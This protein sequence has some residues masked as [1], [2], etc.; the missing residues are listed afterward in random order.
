[1]NEERRNRSLQQSDTGAQVSPLGGGHV[2]EVSG[3]SLNA[4]A[5]SPTT[6][7][8]WFEGTI[9]VGNQL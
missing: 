7:L 2:F 9:D 6:E 3:L 8:C 5:F 4:C 1:M